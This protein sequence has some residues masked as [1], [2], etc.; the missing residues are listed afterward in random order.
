MSICSNSRSLCFAF[1]FGLSS[2]ASKPSGGPI[3]V[4]HI[5]DEEVCVLIEDCL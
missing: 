3:E 5:T 4:S 2:F 1:G